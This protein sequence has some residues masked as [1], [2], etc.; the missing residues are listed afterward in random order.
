MVVAFVDGSHLEEYLAGE[1]VEIDLVPENG[2]SQ[3]VG[4]QQ[5]IFIVVFHVCRVDS[6][7][8]EVGLVVRLPSYRRNPRAVDFALKGDGR[9]WGKLSTR[10]A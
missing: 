8:C 7:T 1:C 2:V 6:V 3:Y 5:G 10:A 9:S 4:R